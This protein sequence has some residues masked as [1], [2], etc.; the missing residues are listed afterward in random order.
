MA[1]RGRE[2]PR[3]Y[4]LGRQLRAREAARC[5]SMSRHA[6]RCGLGSCGLPFQQLLCA[7]SL[8]LII[9]HIRSPLIRLRSRS[10]PPGVQSGPS[11]SVNKVSLLRR[12]A[13]WV[14]SLFSY[15]S[16]PVSPSTQLVKS[17]WI[18]QFTINSQP[19]RIQ[20]ANLSYSRSHRTPSCMSL[21]DEDH[22]N[23]VI[24]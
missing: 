10:Y 19:I 13:I 23:N 21:L 18:D 7:L 15:S 2:S 4:R 11:E 5:V 3:R 24:V 17:F 22:G 20:P 9:R 6:K 14:L 12:P 16:P 1:R 8:G